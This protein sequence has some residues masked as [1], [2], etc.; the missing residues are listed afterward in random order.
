MD[1]R[2]ARKSSGG[3]SG[4]ASLSKYSMYPTRSSATASV[5]SSSPGS[6]SS[7][8][9]EAL[10]SSTGTDLGNIVC[11]TV[12]GSIDS[13]TILEGSSGMTATIEFICSVEEELSNVFSDCRLS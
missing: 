5:S 4:S 7:T 11:M 6:S 8:N 13:S 3:E 1:R 2:V 9:V 10:Y 12:L